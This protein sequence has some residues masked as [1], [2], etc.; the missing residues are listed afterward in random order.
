MAPENG[1]FTAYEH[2]RMIQTNTP[3]NVN[4]FV[5]PILL[6]VLFTFLPSFL[7][8]RRRINLLTAVLTRKHGNL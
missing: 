8:L 1:N 2:K 6:R 5:L 3:I 4:H 7:V